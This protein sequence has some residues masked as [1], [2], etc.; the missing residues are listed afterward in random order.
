MARF[1]IA[2]GKMLVIDPDNE[3]EWKD[4]QLVYDSANDYVGIRPRG[5]SPLDG[6]TFL[7]KRG[8]FKDVVEKGK[9]TEE[10]TS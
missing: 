6:Y 10:L 5:D 8:A 7:V 9:E 1:K 2:T 4:V 3:T